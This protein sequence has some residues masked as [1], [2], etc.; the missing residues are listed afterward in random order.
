MNN[1]QVS[2]QN[3][4]MNYI[5]LLLL[6][7]LLFLRFPFLIL[8]EFYKIPIAKTEGINIFQCGTYLIAAI[9]IF[10]KRNSLLDYHIGFYSLLIF[11]L[12]PVLKPVSKYLLLFTGVSSLKESI[13]WFQIVTSICLFI[14]L[15]IYRPKLRKRSIKEILF[16]LL[17]SVAVG[18]C[19]GI[20]IGSI[21]TLQEKRS[22]NHA[23]ISLFINMFFIQLGNA[24]VME[25]PLFRGFLWGFL[26]NI[27]W[28]DYW[29]WLMQAALFMLGHIYY[30]GIHNY[31]F[32]ITVPFGALVLGLIAWRSRSIGTS[33][34]V[35]GLINSVSDILVH[36]TW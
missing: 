23:S 18:I 31:S 34:I 29:I 26:R 25:E 3:K 2:I 19:S 33:M 6:L 20:I 7:G 15:L 30:L 24:A 21:L 12:T 8:L 14:A 10:L 5:F 9:L 11:I 16:W 28:K 13:S 35:H 4:R 1:I 17:I 36:T 22:L 32:W 27:H